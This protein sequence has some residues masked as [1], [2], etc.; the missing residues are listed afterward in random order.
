MKAYSENWI[1]NLKFKSK[2]KSWFKSGHLNEVELS[3]GNTYFKEDFYKPNWFILMGLFLFTNI[4]VSFTTTFFLATVG[5]FD[6]K[7]GLSIAFIIVSIG[8]FIALEFFIKS[9]NLYRSGIDNALLYLALGFLYASIL[10]FFDFSLPF[11]YYPLFL[12]F[13]LIPAFIRYADPLV[14]IAMFFSF[15]VFVFLF[16]TTFSIGKTILPFVIMSLAASIY[17]I[18]KS[19]LIS[20]YFEDVQQIIKTLSLIVFYIAGNYWVV[21]EANAI[22]NNTFPSIEI[23]FGI[24]FWVFTFFIPFGYIFIGMRK[25]DRKSIIVGILALGFS[26]FTFRCYYAVLPLEWALTLGGLVLVGFSIL[27]LKYFKTPKLNLSSEASEQNKFSKL[28]SILAAQ[29]FQANSPSSDTLKMGGGDFG[30]G[31]SEQSY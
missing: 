10:L 9:K 3:Q 5:I 24:L 16:A 26:I 18:S 4:A 15:F 8:S 20:F 12:F 6:N 11:Y 2:L 22:L 23:P 25:K 27:V 1:E 30:G 21:R 28:E 7:I 13:I 31:G 17:F 19:R 29:A 14:A